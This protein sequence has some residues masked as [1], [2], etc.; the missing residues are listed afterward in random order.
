MGLCMCVRRGEVA[1]GECRVQSRLQTVGPPPWQPHPDPL[2]RRCC[3]S[4]PP[5]APCS[6]PALSLPLQDSNVEFMAHPA[7][8]DNRPHSMQVRRAFRLASAHS[9]AW[10]TLHTLPHT[11]SHARHRSS[12]PSAAPFAAAAGVRALP[13]RG[14]LRPCRVYR[15]A[16][17]QPGHRRPRPGG[18]GP[19][20]LLLLL[21]HPSIDSWS[22]ILDR[23]RALG[24][25]T[26]L[27]GWAA[28]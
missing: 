2:R 22:V 18:Q 12:A 13:H 1:G 28:G 4:R 15:R 14:G 6:Y 19:G 23:L 8:H 3:C 24:S 17:R 7:D 10:P 11:H 25:C 20:P 16:G 27:P 9:P 21:I 5:T 26:L